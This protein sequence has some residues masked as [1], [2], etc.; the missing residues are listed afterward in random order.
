MPS[1]GN[2]NRPPRTPL[3][4]PLVFPLVVTPAPRDGHAPGPSTSTHQK[5]LVWAPVYM[6]S[7]ESIRTSTIP[8]PGGF[9]QSLGR[10]DPWSRPTASRADKKGRR[11][12]S[13][14]G[15]KDC[16]PYVV[17]C[18]P[19]MCGVLALPFRPAAKEQPAEPYLPTHTWNHEHTLSAPHLLG[20]AA[21]RGGHHGNHPIS[22]DR[23]YVASR[24]AGSSV[25]LPWVS[26]GVVV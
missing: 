16:L 12:M 14:R 1:T 3:P 2:K 23:S 17:L 7:A 20:W 10:K 24:R 21:A 22:R 9:E 8:S 26:Q 11:A 25:G 19:L 6:E 15:C 5:W 18:S 13:A 4:P